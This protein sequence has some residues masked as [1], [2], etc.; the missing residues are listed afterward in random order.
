MQGGNDLVCPPTTA[1]ELHE[2]WPEMQLRIVPAGG[3][4]MY[5]AGLQEEV[6]RATDELRDRA[7]EPSAALAAPAVVDSYDLMCND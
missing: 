3:H 1:Y 4:S 6:L 2:A 7:R 5:D